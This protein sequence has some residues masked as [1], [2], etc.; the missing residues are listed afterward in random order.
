MMKASPACPPAAL[1]L[2]DYRVSLISAQSH[3]GVNELTASLIEHKQHKLKTL[4]CL[5]EKIRIGLRE[6]GGN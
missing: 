1:I 6:I 3:V 5:G 2:I 4:F